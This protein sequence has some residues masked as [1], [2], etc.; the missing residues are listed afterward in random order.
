MLNSGISYS[1]KVILS[2][3]H[4]ILWKIIMII[5]GLNRFKLLFFVFY[6]Q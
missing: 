4:T 6:S 1:L 2:Y 3:Y 5:S